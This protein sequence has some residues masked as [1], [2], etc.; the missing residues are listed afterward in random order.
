MATSPHLSPLYQKRVQALDWTANHDDGK[1]IET[2]DEADIVLIGVSGSMKTPVSIYLA[3]KGLRV[4][5]FSWVP[6]RRSPMIYLVG[7]KAPMVVVLHASPEYIRK[8]RQSSLLTKNKVGDLDYVDLE[9]IAQEVALVEDRQDVNE[10]RK[11]NIEGC[12]I[13][14]VAKAVLDLHGYAYHLRFVKEEWPDKDKIV[15][16]LAESAGML[17]RHW[18]P[19]PRQDVIFDL[20]AKMGM[21]IERAQTPE[22]C[23]DAF[24]EVVRYLE[25][26]A[27][28]QSNTPHAAAG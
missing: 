17:S 18:R 24:V 8:V 28:G 21:K 10:W 14:E 1:N 7:P 5:N 26:P 23:V 20:L 9:K 3:N 4:A 11:V 27:N 2:T 15:P 6:G 12:S 19:A 16:L 25:N 22:Q 13:E